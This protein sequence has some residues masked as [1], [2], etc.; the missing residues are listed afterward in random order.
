MKQLPRVLFHGLILATII[1]GFWLLDSLKD[2]ILTKFVGIE[3]Q[4]VAKFCSVVTT[5]IV[6][7]LYDFSTSIFSKQTLFHIIAS[8][9]GMLVLIM[10]AELGD[11]ET[12]LSSSKNSAIDKGP[13]RIIGWV[14]YFTI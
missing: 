6:V 2:P 1:C 13:H 7:C 8:I 11:P 10:A 3:Y 14:C 9:F 5:L 12:G 4:P